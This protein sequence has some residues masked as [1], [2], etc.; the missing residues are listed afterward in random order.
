MA[1]GQLTVNGVNIGPALDHG[2]KISLLNTVESELKLAQA[3]RIKL[4]NLVAK[5]SLSVTDVHGLGCKLVEATSLGP[6]YN[7]CVKMSLVPLE[8]PCYNRPIF[9]IP[10]LV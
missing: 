5:G 6:E 10:V 1:N 7:S 3:E 9:S 8:F 4:S 2:N